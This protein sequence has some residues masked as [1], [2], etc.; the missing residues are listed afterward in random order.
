MP[1]TSNSGSTISSPASGPNACA[2][3]TPR[4]SSTTGDGLIRARPSYSAV[5]RSQSV[6]SATVAR[7]WQAA[8]AACRAYGP[9][10]PPSSLDPVDVGQ[11]AP[12]QQAV[13]PGAV[14]VEQQHRLAVGADPGPQP[15]GLDLDQREQAQRLGVVRRQ[16][17]PASGRAGAPRRTGRRGST[18]RRWWPSGPR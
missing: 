11:A 9:T 5:I 8:I 15:R 4:L 3:A 17:R 1:G 14:L 12:D 13:P 16:R 7:A 6:S 2:V 18:G 10:V